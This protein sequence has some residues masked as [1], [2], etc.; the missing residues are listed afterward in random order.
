MERSAA[1]SL[2]RQG[3]TNPGTNA[4]GRERTNEKPSAVRAEVFRDVV[5]AA[6]LWLCLPRLPRRKFFTDVEM[7]S[8]TFTSALTSAFGHNR[9]LGPIAQLDREPSSNPGS[10]SDKHYSLTTIGRCS[11]NRRATRRCAAVTWVVR[12][13]RRHALS[14]HFGEK[15]RGRSIGCGHLSEDGGKRMG[16]Q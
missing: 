13:M 1:G 7:R 4:L 10:A 3:S 11:D 14:A 6:R 8:S 5:T 15:H 12:S 16:Q 2:S 9:S